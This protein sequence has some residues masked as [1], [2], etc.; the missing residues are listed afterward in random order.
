MKKIR[1]LQ[2]AFDALLPPYQLPAFRAAIA[3]KAG[4]QHVN[5]HNHQSD[6]G[7]SILN[8]P[9]IQYKLESLK[10]FRTRPML[11]C[12]EQGVED[13]YHFFAQPDWTLNIL[14]ESMPLRIAKLDV[15]QHV[16]TMG[17]T[18]FRYRLHK[19]QALN[20]SNYAEW[21]AILED[22]AAQHNFLEKC[23]NQHIHSFAKGVDWAIGKDWD[24]KITQVYKY[25][26]IE[27]KKV[28]TLAFTIDFETKASLP[29]FIGL[30]KGVAFGFGVLRRQKEIRYNSC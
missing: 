20:Q 24:I 21:Q 1:I 27:F 10:E 13:A 14:G 2:V 25:E 4:F 8:Y 23:L 30:G 17:D 3:E 22:R 5:F 15:R 18:P 19:W 16:L 9:L 12:L 6:T 7:K 26:W 11:V 28:R 29:D